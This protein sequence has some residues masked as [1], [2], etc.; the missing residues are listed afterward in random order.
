MSFYKVIESQFRNGR[1]RGAWIGQ[2]IPTLTG[3]AAERVRELRAAQ[4]DVG[5]HIFQSGRCAVAHASL[6]GQLVDPDIPEDRVRIDSDL[7]VIQALAKKYI[8]EE[9]EV[10][11]QMDVYRNRDAL[12]PVYKYIEQNHVEELMN[13]VSVLGKKLGL[14]GLCVSINHWPHQSPQ[15]LQNLKLSVA[16]VQNGIVDLRATNDSGT[17]S[18]GFL[19]AFPQRK[20]ETNLYVSGV[21]PTNQGGRL[22]E[23]IAFL[24]YQKAVIGNGII[25]MQLPN[26]EKIVC[27]EVIPV[28]IDI[29]RTFDAID[30]KIAAL[31]STQHGPTGNENN[32][33]GA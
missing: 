5:E 20:A 23:E 1:A 27:E 2:S 16:S 25:E 32:G 28:N 6:S 31:Q 17:I 30:D 8:K 13:G 15:A 33:H 7:V 22:D 14:N 11:D 12:R 4:L 9:L 24:E 21:L 18:L 19:L 26:Y 3:K 10:P 29:G